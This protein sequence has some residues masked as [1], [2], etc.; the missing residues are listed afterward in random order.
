MHPLKNIRFFFRVKNDH[1]AFSTRA[2]PSVSVLP[3]VFT[4]RT[5]ISFGVIC[6]RAAGSAATR[7]RVQCSMSLKMRQQ[8]HL[9]FI[10]VSVCCRLAACN[11]FINKLTRLS[12]PTLARYEPVVANDLYHRM[13]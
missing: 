8:R 4:E 5:D 3:R 13:R 9:W 10:P 6:R 12:P 1:R 2:L 7:V 11:F